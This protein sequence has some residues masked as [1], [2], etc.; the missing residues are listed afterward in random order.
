MVGVVVCVCN[1]KVWN[2]KDKNVKE[3][4]LLAKVFDQW[5][6]AQ[7]EKIDSSL[8]S[9]QDG[10]GHEHMIVLVAQN[11]PSQLIMTRTVSQMGVVNPAL[12]IKIKEVLSWLKRNR[13]T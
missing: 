8:F 6:C 3:V 9:L 5:S 13:A 4:V 1:G 7:D 10:E 12:A 11:S 2:D